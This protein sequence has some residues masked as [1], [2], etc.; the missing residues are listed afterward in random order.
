VGPHS[1]QRLAGAPAAAIERIRIVQPMMRA[2]EERPRD[3]LL[4]LQHLSNLDKH[5][6][7]VEASLVPDAVNAD[8]RVD[9]GSDEA[10]EKN[11]PPDV[12]VPFPEIRDGSLLV[13]YLT[14]TGILET[15]G[16]LA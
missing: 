5:R 14:K 16:A 4:L 10:A 6:S 11:P 1:Q 13:E 9:F 3:P 12:R 7:S 2:P 8:F 15:S